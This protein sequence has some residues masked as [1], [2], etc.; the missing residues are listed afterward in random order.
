MTKPRRGSKKFAKY[1]LN[2][3]RARYDEWGNYN[4]GIELR[5]GWVKLGSGVSRTAY[6]GPDGNVYKVDNVTWHGPAPSA[7]YSNDN[8]SEWM[9]ILT[10]QERADIP[11]WVMIPDAHL[12]TLGKF[13]VMCME[14]ID[15]SAKFNSWCDA[16]NGRQC[17][18]KG[19][20]YFK[21][22]PRCTADIFRDLQAAGFDDVHNDNYWLQI[23]GRVA[24]VDV[25]L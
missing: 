10:H 1:I 5:T 24:V 20:D 19:L 16:A 8:R 11:A 23:D 4:S 14:V 22:Y 6:L 18:C 25:G 12:F 17:D 2:Y 3:H 7:Y 13:A 15:T 9:A 21:F